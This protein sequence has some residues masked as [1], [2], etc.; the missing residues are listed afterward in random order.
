ME[1][2]TT[3]MF[4]LIISSIFLLL[5]IKVT[6]R[7]QKIQREDLGI[8]M[9]TALFNPFLY[10]VG[11]SFGLDRVS[12]TISSVI[13][14]TIPIFMPFAAY[15]YLKERLRLINS[16]GLAISFIGVIV[17]VV[18]RSFSLK[19]DPLGLAFL[20]L[21]VISAIIYGILLKKLT[22]NYS[23]LTIITYQN[24]IGIVY[25][26]PLV[27]LLE[28]NTL[29]NVQPDFRMVSSLLLLGVFAS[30]LAFVF[31]V[32]AIKHLGIAKA[33]IYTNMI[34][35]FTALFSL[36]ILHELITAD[37]IA[38]IILVIAGLVLSQQG[39]KHS[40]ISVRITNPTIPI[41]NEKN[42][43]YRFRRRTG[44]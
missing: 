40:K 6:K 23:P 43:S 20:F 13:I 32:K 36:W 15:L 35:V 11:E 10:F 34:P 21:A 8:F 24:M 2:A 22:G 19:A 4:R 31:F 3:V 44:R 30:S 29:L 12:P 33:N 5:L 27:L 39:K 42:K 37:K 18:D 14:A 7:Y 25:F 38:G 41:K 9:L 26:A 17:I 28:W 1:P 16:I